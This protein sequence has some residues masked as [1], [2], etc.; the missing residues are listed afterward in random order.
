MKILCR[1]SGMLKN[2][3]EIQYIRTRLAC[4][5]Q[6]VLVQTG[7]FLWLC[8][9]WWVILIAFQTHQT[10]LTV[11]KYENTT[12]AWQIMYNDASWETRWACLWNILSLKPRKQLVSNE[13][14]ANEK[15]DSIHGIHDIKVPRILL[16][17]FNWFFRL[18]L[19][20]TFYRTMW[21][22]LL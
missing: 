3:N 10:F 2:L 9:A 8:S 1:L 16:A 6:K 11:E 14:K 15:T 7:S 4:G 19:D 20:F 18:H 5:H 13:G 17:V 12:A 22:V 21:C